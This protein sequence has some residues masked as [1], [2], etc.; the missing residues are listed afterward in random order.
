MIELCEDMKRIS[1]FVH[2]SSAFSNGKQK[3]IEE[4]VYKPPIDPFKVVNNIGNMS[5]EGRKL[6]AKILTVRSWQVA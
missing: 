2:V 4:R 5:T 1:V 3:R 6:L